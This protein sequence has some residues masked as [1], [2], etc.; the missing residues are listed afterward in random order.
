MNPKQTFEKRNILAIESANAV[1]VNS[2]G[3][4][5]PNVCFNFKDAGVKRSCFLTFKNEVFIFGGRT[6]FHRA[7]Y[8]LSQLVDH[9]LRRI[10]E[11]PFEFS[12]G[13]CANAS[14]RRIYLCFNSGFK[15]RKDDQK[16]CHFATD[17]R[18]NFTRMTKSNSTHLQITL[19]VSSNTCELNL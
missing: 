8:Q 7:A 9:E 4:Y 6:D 13:A 2:S 18:E 15:D 14:N 10:G 17:P 19:A 3:Y 16:T 12:F 5:N 1:I 11:L